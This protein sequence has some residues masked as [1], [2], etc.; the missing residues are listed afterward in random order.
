[1]ISRN[2]GFFLTTLF[3]FGYR[4]KEKAI[5][6]VTIDRQNVTIIPIVIMIPKSLTT[7]RLLIVRDAKPTA[8]V[9]LVRK[10]GIVTELI[11]LITV[12]I[13]LKSGYFLAYLK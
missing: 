6:E 3:N 8:V 13:L 1:M 11:L 4:N 12:L 5:D 7:D 10:Q 9:R 2:P